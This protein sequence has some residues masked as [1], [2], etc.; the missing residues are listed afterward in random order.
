MY[1]SNKDFAQDRN[2]FLETIES[3]GDQNLIANNEFLKH[4]KGK[5]DEFGETIYRINNKADRNIHIPYSI[6]K[7]KT[8]TTDLQPIRYRQNVQEQ[9][10]ERIEIES[11]KEISIRSLFCKS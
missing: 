6:D 1:Y 4:F 9:N 8:Q 2:A 5:D 7:T 3:K 10:K 11:A